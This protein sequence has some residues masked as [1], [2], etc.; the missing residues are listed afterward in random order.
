MDELS[1]RWV[2]SRPICDDHPFPGNV[3]V[4]ADGFKRQYSLGSGD[5]P[6]SESERICRSTIVLGSGGAE[7]S[8]NQSNGN[9]LTEWIRETTGNQRERAEQWGHM[10]F[11]LVETRSRE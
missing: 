4:P 3:A 7:D 1:R 6:Y 9:E 2:R 8:G 10:Q 5:I 11:V